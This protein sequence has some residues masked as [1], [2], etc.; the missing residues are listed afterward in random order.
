MLR[1][2]LFS[3]LCLMGLSLQ[4]WADEMPFTIQSDLYDESDTETL[5]LTYAPGT[6]TVTIF[7]P[8]DATDKFSNGIVMTAFKGA[9]YCMW[10]SSAKDEDA[11]D[12]WVAY[13]RSTD[14]G[15]TWT[16]PMVLAK[17]LDN[18]YCSSGGWLATEDKLIGF[19]NTW[20]GN[21][22][23]KGGYTRYVSSEDGMTWTEPA[24][25]KMADG[26][27]LNGI[28]EQD[29][30]VLAD[31]RIVNSAHFQPGLKICPIYT[32][33]PLGISGW[34]KG[35]FSYTVN[36]DQSRELE[37]SLYQKADGTLV[38]VFRDQNSTFKKM[39]ATSSD[40]GETW[41]KA[42]VTD[43]PDSRSK[44]SAGNLPD[45][46]VY[47]ASNPVNNKTRIPLVLT[48]SKDGNHFDQAWL[49][50]AGGDD[51][52]P[53]RY[54]GTAKRACYSYPKSMV[55]DGY[56]YVAYATNKEDVEYTRVPLS[57]IQLNASS[58]KALNV[59]GGLSVY[60]SGSRTLS[61]VSDKSRSL[62]ITL[63][64]ITGSSVL[65]FA[66]DGTSADYSLEGLP[67]G[68]YMVRVKSTDKVITRKVMLKD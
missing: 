28:F 30:H 9:L 36:G 37:P 41:T 8:T 29:P 62:D 54:S 25:V 12:T 59:V 27:T 53:L 23:P 15:K 58:V 56:I 55:Y 13:S 67:A 35:S 51:L 10:Q 4:V 61:V 31:G 65:S 33:D 42:V 47:T 64:N 21:L 5:G 48:L 39:A 17:T 57:S 63:Y 43:F 6:E 49:L 66:V 68:V 45:G 26:T 46:T 52:Q 60:L 11:S 19:I 18:G 40:R 32:D 34:K 2:K 24:D 1:T 7:A 38:M 16:A 14:G 22:S 44:Q 20:P 3:V 50:R